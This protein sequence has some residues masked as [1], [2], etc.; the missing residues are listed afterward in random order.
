[1]SNKCTKIAQTLSQASVFVMDKLLSFLKLSWNGGRVYPSLFFKCIN[2]NLFLFLLVNS[3]CATVFSG[4]KSQV[5]INSNPSGAIVRINGIK[6]GETPLLLNL[7]GSQKNIEITIS[8]EGYD[9]KKIIAKS[10]INRISFL[11]LI[12]IL[13]WSVDCISG[14]L[15]TYDLKYCDVILKKSHK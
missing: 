14:S 3:S 7:E 10:R 11:N 2:V 4:A 5:Q 13:G 9:E 12:N 6:Q 1:M 8:A 15:W